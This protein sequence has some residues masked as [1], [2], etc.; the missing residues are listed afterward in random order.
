MATSSSYIVEDISEITQI[1]NTDNDVTLSQIDSNKIATITQIGSKNDVDT[2]N[3]NKTTIS[4]IGNENT[5]NSTDTNSF[6]IY[7]RGDM[8]E[9]TVTGYS[10]SVVI[11]QIGFNNISTVSQ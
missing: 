9:A 3:G 11:R 7:Q 2:V 10:G 6:S 8:N 4:Q 1:N 5:V